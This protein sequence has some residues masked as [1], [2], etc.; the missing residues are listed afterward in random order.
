MKRL[1]VSSALMSRAEEASAAQSPATITG[2]WN[3]YNTLVL[4]FFQNLGERS[5]K[6]AIHAVGL[7][8][9]YNCCMSLIS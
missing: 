2:M 5:S 9:R 6:F 7:V 3:W 1:C 4:L 8:P